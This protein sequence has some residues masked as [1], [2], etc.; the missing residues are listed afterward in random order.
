[1]AM[2]K[3]VLS[4]K[5]FCPPRSQ[6]HYQCR[7]T[8]QLLWDK[9]RKNGQRGLRA[10]RQY[11]RDVAPPPYGTLVSKSTVVICIICLYAEIHFILQLLHHLAFHF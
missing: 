7:P 11:C 9:K 10:D 6:P 1:M 8:R 3:A 4:P 5:S 2:T